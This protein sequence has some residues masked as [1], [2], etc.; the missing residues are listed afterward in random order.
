MERA[1]VTLPPVM[2]DPACFLSLVNSAVEVYNRETTGMLVGSE[3]VRVLQ[4]RRR[5]V[6]ALDAAMPFQTASRSVTWVEPSNHSA[7]HRARAAPGS[8][9]F[10]V[11]GEYHSHTNNEN[12]LS[13]ADVDYALEALRRMNGHAPKQWLELVLGMRRKEYGRP[14]EPGWTWRDYRRKAGCTVVLSPRAGFDITIA[15]YWIRPNGDDEH[16]RCDEA[17]VYIPWSNRYWT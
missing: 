3:R 1:P 2:V 15:G 14:R 6:V 9:G 10:R 7:V 11:L 12:G 4:G 13:R 8:L 5:R 16:V 17:T